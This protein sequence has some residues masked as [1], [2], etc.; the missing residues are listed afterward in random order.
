MEWVPNSPSFLALLLLFVV[1]F[2]NNNS[3]LLSKLNL[4]PEIPSELCLYG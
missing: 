3:G 2:N 1:V 4:L